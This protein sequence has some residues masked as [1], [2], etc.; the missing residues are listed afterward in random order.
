M[1]VFLS[2]SGERS[3]ALAEALRE[4]LPLVIQQAQP[5]FS[6]ED[7]DKGSRWLADLTQQLQKQGIAIV[8][9]TRESLSS[10]WLLFEAGALSKALDASWVCPVLLDVEPSDL[11]GPLAQFQ[12]TRITKEDIRR[13]LG[14]LNKRLEAPLADTQI[15]R[16]H[17]LLWP[18]FEAK[19]KKILTEPAKT[20]TPRRS[21]ADLLAEVLE[22]VR[23][24]ERRLD[25]FPRRE[26]A[27]DL[28]RTTQFGIASAHTAWRNGKTLQEK[29]NHFQHLSRQTQAQL[30][31]L[32]TVAGSDKVSGKQKAGLQAQIAVE[33]DKLAQYEVEISR[34]LVKLTRANELRG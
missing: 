5:W 31:A 15:D 25:D 10:A 17:D 24:L 2:W 30:M 3:K 33:R 21:Q 7:I 12:S 16:L 9:I 28:N 14:T 20:S 6:P 26:T 19:I 32:E 4:H 34:H 1:N 23:G 13:L 27:F 22:R 18:D 11:N 8:C 29:V